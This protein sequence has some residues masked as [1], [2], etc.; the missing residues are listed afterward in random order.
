LE[1][2][3]KEI[4][5]HSLTSEVSAAWHEILAWEVWATANWLGTHN[6]NA[7]TYSICTFLLNIFYPFT[8]DYNL[9]AQSEPDYCFRW[10]LLITG[11][12]TPRQSR[13]IY[14]VRFDERE[15]DLSARFLGPGNFRYPGLVEENGPFK[16]KSP[17]VMI[18]DREEKRGG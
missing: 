16:R 4:P 5:F 9:F 12:I 15:F 6:K 14:R 13:V 11:S 1:G 18:D 8:V 10:P 17:R 2:G 3:A 7:I